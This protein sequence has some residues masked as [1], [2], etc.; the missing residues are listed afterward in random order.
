MGRGKEQEDR[1]M[2]SETG[3]PLHP[4]SFPKQRTPNEEKGSERSVLGNIQSNS[5]LVVQLPTM[6]IR[7][8]I[9]S[10]NNVAVS[11]ILS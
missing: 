11:Y 2:T 3:K 8:G 9:L 1:G 5:F 7:D 4:K 10:P 6:H